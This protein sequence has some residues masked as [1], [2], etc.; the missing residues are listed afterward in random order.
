MFNFYLLPFT[1]IKIMRKI[2]FIITILFLLSAGRAFSADADVTASAKADKTRVTIGDPVNYVVTLAC[3]QNYKLMLPDKQANIGQWEVKD[4]KVF[5]EKKDKL[6]S[7]LNYSL[8]AYTTGQMDI[9]ETEF[10]FLDVNNSTVTVKAPGAS[11]TVD[12]V[13]GLVKGPAGLRDIKPPVS[14]KIPVGI[15]LLCLLVIAALAFGGWLWYE[16]YRKKLPRLPEGPV[17]PA[18]PPFQT[19]LEELDKLKN[20]ELIKEGRI[21]EFYI[22]LSDIIRK[23]LGAIYSFDTLDKTTAEIYLELRRAVADKKALVFIRDFFDECD[24]VKFAKYRPEEKV[25]W[26]DFENAVKIIKD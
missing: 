9:P 22:T 11:I 24:F 21:K 20:S 3:P 14:L 6:F 4:F 25:I 19:A 8:A 15:Y 13:L 7:Y 18:V 16:D 17:I 1:G 10:S 5:Q 26:E 23:Y 12:S 2:L